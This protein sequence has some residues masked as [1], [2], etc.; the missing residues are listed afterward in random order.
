M[1]TEYG[2]LE[3]HL[4]SEEAKLGDSLRFIR[5]DW[6]TLLFHESCRDAVW[7]MIEEKRE[8]I[9]NEADYTTKRI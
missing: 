7:E 6:T 8:A 4:C 2:Q 3:C 5:F 1:S 9:K